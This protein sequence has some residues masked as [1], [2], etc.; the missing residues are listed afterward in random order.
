MVGPDPAKM[1][2]SRF[3]TLACSQLHGPDEGSRVAGDG[4][5]PRHP[6]GEH[7]HREPEPRSSLH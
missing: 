1:F 5:R 4:H 3:A 2:G 6:P 7:E